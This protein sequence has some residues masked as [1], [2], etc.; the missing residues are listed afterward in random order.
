MV[1]T[2]SPNAP[3]T[4]S[5][6][7]C[8]PYRRIPRKLAAILLL[9]FSLFQLVAPLSQCLCS[10]SNKKNGEVGE[11][12]QQAKIFFNKYNF[13]ITGYV[14]VRTCDFHCKMCS[15][16]TFFHCLCSALMEKHD[17]Y[18]YV[19]PWNC[20]WYCTAQVLN[21]FTALSLT[22]IRTRE[23]EREREREIKYTVN[24]QRSAQY[25]LLLLYVM[26]VMSYCA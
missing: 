8:P 16:N 2:S 15:N 26:L 7:L 10:E 17:F 12:P 14:P 13:L 9:A 1:Y 3:S 4:W 11:Y 6:F 24:V 20:T 19:I 21:F 18:R 23:R 22:F 5:I 25:T